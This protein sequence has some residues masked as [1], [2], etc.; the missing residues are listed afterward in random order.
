MGS[1]GGGPRRAGGP[2]PPLYRLPRLTGATEPRAGSLPGTGSPDGAPVTEKEVPQ[3]VSSLAQTCN[4]PSPRSSR[5]RLPEA[6]PLPRNRTGQVNKKKE[7][8]NPD[9]GYPQGPSRRGPR[10]PTPARIGIRPRASR[11]GGEPIPR[12]GTMRA[13][14]R[15]YSLAPEKTPR[16]GNQ[17]GTET[18][19]GQCRVRIG[20][21]VAPGNRRVRQ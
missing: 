4:R 1:R 12:R 16:A 7:L 3:D 2:P 14:L 15:A 18:K 19:T 17:G 10:D 11:A 21:W 5:Q 13:E 20:Q 8:Y 6:L 9:G